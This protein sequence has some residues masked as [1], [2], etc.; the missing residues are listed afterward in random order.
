MSAQMM[1]GT[2]PAIKPAPPRRA[3]RRREVGDRI[4]SR[5][6]SDNRRQAPVFRGRAPLVMS[7]LSR[8]L[9]SSVGTKILVALTGLGFAAFL[10]THL[11]ANLLVLVDPHGYNEYS[12][13]LISNP[14]IYI[15]E[16][17]LVALFVV[18]AVQAVLVTVRNRQ[19]RGRG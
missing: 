18:H 16:A 3:G 7:S 1:S 8:F 6:A 10:A 12:H 4:D 19:A 13:K 9:S 2:G 15:A 11:A 14:L 5:P 17:A